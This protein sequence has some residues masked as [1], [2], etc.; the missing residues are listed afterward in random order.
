MSSGRR[1]GIVLAG[2]G[3][4]IALIM[5][6]QMLADRD[7]DRTR[8]AEPATS[9]VV[10]EGRLVLPPR[11]RQPAQLYLKIANR[12]TN[13]IYVTAVAVRQA[14]EAD[15]FDTS[16]PSPL[17]VENVMVEPGQVVSIEPGT[18]AAQVTDYSS[19][20]VPGAMVDVDLRLSNSQ[21]ISTRARVEAYRATGT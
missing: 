11:A 1:I 8:P 2:I 13:A 18:R 16:R 9:V 12:G 15:F 6:V 10:S 3:L 17:R 5:V 20:V 4:V 21:T 19:D 7:G 14:R